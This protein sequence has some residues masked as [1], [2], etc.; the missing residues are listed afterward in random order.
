MLDTP[1]FE[2]ID[3]YTHVTLELLEDGET[4]RLEFDLVSAQ[5]ADYYQG[6][7]GVDTSLGQAILGQRPGSRL[8]YFM[9]ETPIDVRILAI[10]PTTRL[11]DPHRLD[12]RQAT[13]QQAVTESVL[14]DRL[15]VATSMGNKWGDLD[16]DGF[17]KSIEKPET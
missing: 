8:T 6:F 11:A 2:K 14:K 7:L 16:A 9:G 13:I 15:A 4:Q 1:L 10:A 5:E 3:L 12:Q 17:A